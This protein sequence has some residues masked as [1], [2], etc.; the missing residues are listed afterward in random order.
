MQSDQAAKQREK[1][2]SEGVIVYDSLP[3]SCSHRALILLFSGSYILLQTITSS[4]LDIHSS[5][6]SSNSSIIPG[7][8]DCSILI[9][10]GH[11]LPTRVRICD[12]VLKK[13]GGNTP[14][15]EPPLCE[16]ST[17][18]LC[19]WAPSPSAIMVAS[20][21][22]ASRRCLQGPP[23]WAGLFFHAAFYP[24]SEKTGPAL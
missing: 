8:A 22:P 12:F 16:T 21:L 11:W 18:R 7:I 3:I 15:L 1:Y 6:S 2:L 10:C 20:R 17:M 9:A 13:R 24:L 4:T 5:S 14:T 23:P 19:R